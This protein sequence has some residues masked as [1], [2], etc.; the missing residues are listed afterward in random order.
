MLGA[1]AIDKHRAHP[2]RGT[3]Q[4]TARGIGAARTSMPPKVDSTACPM[5]MAGGGS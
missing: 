5:S 1:A 3:E 2:R 4:A